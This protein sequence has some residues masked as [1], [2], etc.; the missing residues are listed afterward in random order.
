[1]VVDI[2]FLDFFGKGKR[3]V[4]GREVLAGEKKAG[5]SCAWH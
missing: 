2:I 1:M 4:G 3:L 5:F